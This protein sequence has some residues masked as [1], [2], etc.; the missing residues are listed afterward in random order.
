MK[1]AIIVGTRPEIIRLSRV[2]SKLEHSF[3]FDL[4]LIH[5]GQN[6]DYELSEIFFQDLGIKLKNP[7]VYLNAAEQGKNNVGKTIGK[8]IEKSY[9]ILQE[10]QPDAV[11]ILGDTNSCL[12][13]ISAKRLKIPIFHMEAGNRCFD[14]RV[15]EEI[16]RKIVDHISDVNMTYSDISREYL[17]NAGLHPDRII[18]VGSPM[19]EVINHYWVK[20][21]HIV[22]RFADICNSIEKKTNVKPENKNFFLVSCHREENI[23]T[24]NLTKFFNMLEEITKTYEIPAFVS[25]HPRLR[26]KLDQLEDPIKN[27]HFLNPMPFTEYLYLQSI[28]KVV[29]SDSGT[30][31]EEA[32]IIGFS[33]INIRETH[34]RPEANEEMPIIMTGMNIDRIN[35]AISLF[36]FDASSSQYGRVKDYH[37]PDVS[38]KVA[39]ILLS[40][41]DYVNKNVWRHV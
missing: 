18:K 4:T 13:A 35:E 12:S 11:L 32:S 6:Y 16:N 14:E 36:D 41:T 26:N 38:E 25:T 3:A 15:P 30:I 19:F 23:D 2:I 33:A 24:D 8:I 37:N 21:S 29:L 39:R 10:I 27:V 34:E 20:N 5:T 9:N 22:H 1:I 17:V 7:I 31:S 40:Y 28:A